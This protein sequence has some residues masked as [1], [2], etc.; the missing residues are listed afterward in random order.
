MQRKHKT[1]LII[2]TILAIAISGCG[3]LPEAQPTPDISGAITAT[4]GAVQT[5]AAATVQAGVAQTQAALPTAEPPTSS[6]TAIIPTQEPATSTPNATQN[7]P[8]IIPTIVTLAP[9]ATLRPTLPPAAVVPTVCKIASQSPAWG[10]AF[11]PGGD[12]DGRVKLENISGTTWDDGSVDFKYVSGTKFQTNVDSFD[13]PKDVN[14]GGSVEFVI[15]ML[16]PRDPG[17]YVSTWAL[18]SSTS[19]LCLITWSIRVQ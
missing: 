2:I 5:E 17:T 19:Q 15:D 7:V 11:P 10:Y 16:A 18:T 14:N 9:T 12:F 13:L 3:V 1:T 6:P 4:L 8:Q